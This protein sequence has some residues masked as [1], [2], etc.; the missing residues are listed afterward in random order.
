MRSI[1]GL[2]LLSSACGLGGSDPAPDAG[3]DDTLPKGG[4]PG[5]RG[6]ATFF[7]TDTPMAA[8]GA[9]KFIIAGAVS[10][11]PTIGGVRSSDPAVF[12]VRPNAQNQPPH[13]MIAIVTTHHT[14]T[15]DLILTDPSGAEI[16][17]TPLI[18]ADT[19][20]LRVDHGWAGSAPTILADTP[21][22]FHVFTVARDGAGHETILA[23]SGAVSFQGTGTITV[24]PRRAG[25][26]IADLAALTGSAGN[27]SIQANCQTAQ[28]EVPI[29]VVSLTALTSIVAPSSI[30]LPYKG[31]SFS[32]GALA[33][34]T[35]VYGVACTTWEVP[36]GVTVKA[37]P[38]N[39][40]VYPC[41]SADPI[42]DLSQAPSLTYT[43]AGLLGTYNLTC[44]IPGGLRKT[45]AV[46]LY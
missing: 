12:E 10:T 37:P 19:N 3:T 38:S 33:G 34:T 36:V 35:P 46:T 5:L 22:G 23:G 17:H 25:D 44:T 13:S 26:P 32:I 9:V 40:D 24:A 15:A 30:S 39:C 31:G 21:V 7:N 45:I 8:G 18:I 11:A 27:G 29:Q 16:D 14:G 20:V 41:T 28:I 4:T 2:C 6:L 43:V 1:V 42:A